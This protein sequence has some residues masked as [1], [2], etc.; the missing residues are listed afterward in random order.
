MKLV[1]NRYK[2][3]KVLE[4]N[5]YSSIYEVVD[6]WNDDKRLFMKLY[7]IDKQKKVIDYFINNFV[8]L[9]RIKHKYLLSSEQFSIIKTIDR[10]RVNIKQYYCTTE[11]ID[12][13]CLGK[14]HKD[15]SLHEKLM[16]I[17]QAC[18]VLDFLHYR[19]IVYKH[20]SP[21]NIFLSEDDNIKIMDLANVY[22]ASINTSYTDLTRYFIAPEVLLDQKDMINKNAD[23]YSLGML[24]LYL[25]T[26]DF[27]SS[28]ISYEYRDAPQ[29]NSRQIDFLNDLITRLTRKNPITREVSLRNLVDNLKEI[30]NIDYDYNIVKERGIL[31]FKTQIVGRE[32]EI[33]KVLM[34]DKK[35][36]KGKEY[37]K[38]ILINGDSGVGK[39]RL[40]KE[41][42]HLLRMRGRDVYYLEI[43]ENI[44]QGLKPATNILRQTIKDVPMNVLNKYAKELIKVLPE[45]KFVVNAETLDE[46]GGDRERLRLYDRITNYLEEFTKDKPVYL[47]IDNLGDCSLEFLHLLDY[48]IDNISEGSLIVIGSYNEK[49]LGDTSIKANIFYKLTGEETVEHIKISNLNLTEIGEFI[50][51]VLGIS[52][53]PL[54]FSAVMLRESAGNPRYIEYMMKDLYATGELFLSTEGF[55]EIK[56]QRYSD[57]YFPS[58]ID[59]AMKNQISLIE[60]G[61]LEIMKIVSVYNDSIS[62]IILFQMID[63]DN[64][65]LNTK[66]SELVGMGLLEEKV[67]DWGYSYSISNIHLKRLIYHR[68]PSYERIEL[69][70]KLA[71]LLEKNYGTNYKVI[72]EELIYHLRASH[73]T[74]KALDYTI[75]E[76]R[77]KSNIL[78]TQ[79]ILLWEEAYDIAKGTE[80]DYKLEILNSL[81]S[82]YFL[83][84]EYDKAL[85]VYKE[86]FDISKSKEE[87]KYIV[88]ANIGIGEIYL[89]RSLTDKALKK[90]KEAI[91]ISKEIDYP[92]GIVKSRILY[93]KIL[94]NHGKFDESQ[95]NIIELLDFVM[96]YDLYQELGDIYNIM[97][98]L[99][100]FNGNVE[101][102]IGLYRNSIKSYHQVDEFINSTKPINNIANIYRQYGEYKKA[103]EYYEDGLKI[104]EKYG[105]LNI[106]LVFLN[107]VGE[108]YF[109]LCDYDK[110]KK[111]IEEARTIALEVKDPNLIFL[112]NINLGLIYLLIGDYEHS[113]N[114]YEIIKE[115]YSQNS[116]FSFEVISQYYN[117]LGEFYYTFGKWDEALKYSTNSMKLCKDYN[118]TEYLM[119]KTR[120]ILTNYFKNQN[121]DKK[122]ME[123]IRAEFRS[124]NLGFQRRANLLR[125]GIVA[126]LENDYKYVADII[127]E[128]NKLKKDYTSPTLEY[129]RKLLLYSITPDEDS[130]KN[131]MKLEENMKKYNLVHLD[132]YA[133]ILIGVNFT[134]DEKY[135]QAI[136]Y[137][138]QSL[139]LI[140]GTIKNIPERDLQV[141]FIKRHR[142]DNIK[143]KLLEVMYKIFN[144]RLDCICID[145]IGPNDNIEKY[146]DY[147]SLFSLIDDSQFTKIT[148]MN[149]LYEETKDIFTIEDL[150]KNLTNDYKYNLKLILKYISK[151]AFAQRGYILIYDE[152]NNRYTPI[153]S[154][155]GHM[156]WKP[157]ENLLALAGRYE[158]GILISSSLVS[159]VIGL[160]KEFLPKDTRAL[161]CVP[162]ITPPNEIYHSGEERRKN[163]LQYNRR[164][165]GYIYLETGRIFNRFDKERQR[166]ISILTRILYINIEN[167][168]F[169]ILSNIDR[170]TGTYTRKYLDN[171][172]NRI[173]IEAKRKDESFA[174]MMMDLD[175]FKNIND[176]YGHRKGDEVLSL[177]GSTLSNSIR[178]TDIVAR[179]GGEEFIILLKDVN[180]EQV[181]KIG[182]K[183]RLSVEKL[184]ISNI[185]NPITIS[186][187]ISMFPV[188]SQFKEEL[189][190]KADQA[191]YCAKEKGRNKVVIWNTNLANT[192]N[193]VDRLAGILSGNTN[194]DQRNIL[195]ILDIIDIIK[196][197]IS[198][199]EKI[200]A[201]LGRTIETL[202][203]ENG[204]FIEVDFN[205]N[206]TNIYARSRLN[207]NWTE[208]SFINEAIVDRILSQRKG[209]FLID[210]E[211]VNE[212]N[213]V[214]NTPN[215]ESV[216]AI[217]LIFKDEIK[218][219]VYITVP[220]KEKEF[221]YNNY[222][223]TKVLCD[224]FSTLF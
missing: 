57:I 166:L 200:F 134:V 220:I 177:I 193:R 60:K 164:K 39:T 94:L 99:E 129:I 222:N 169:K 198:K 33:K 20:L 221:D 146:F 48:I 83:K 61:Y 215:W 29:M 150:I 98:L 102:A 205:N 6:F 207:Q 50:Q 65:Y 155:N 32:K 153:I 24:M 72:F 2:V 132:I 160:H 15:L 63:D 175:R 202:E 19:G 183:I 128:D 110:A 133:N 106:K 12:S 121:Y 158:N 40:L 138:L 73:Q 117:F 49:T 54:K 192:L 196:R 7:N 157:N 71:R 174:V 224:I 191:L 10:K 135:Y 219:L 44:Q 206:P 194:M 170:L 75:K 179:Y 125:L 211:S 87:G 90:A 81:G 199:K 141:G 45:L 69:H 25:L 41:T 17:I 4:D 147:N 66:I 162:I 115:S 185:E 213:L 5:I 167:Y 28:N 112:T 116:N 140:Y 59:E 88:I 42:S 113:Y 100:Y 209:E 86:L 204:A 91:K 188:H 22:E 165:E 151:E 77:E 186:I 37:K 168:K 26:N 105:I 9:T 58:S 123:D 38:A 85:N 96:E 154:L 68:I 173:L 152:E 51:Y 176:I 70:K 210:W 111:Y 187:G 3:N 97:G 184:K 43:T 93:N 67:A 74:E 82:I 144:K 145:D 223:L 23:K 64:D 163:Q 18:T 124:I 214:L 118:N 126:L 127:E 195:A 159:N 30:F 203:A 208:A 156:N 21:S 139:D 216:I 76:A 52:Y 53:K 171:E 11:Y 101:K 189:I 149:Y 143:I 79:S 119:S 190:E 84:G 47:I 1:D 131:L 104:V 80:S 122:S 161:I 142:T 55:W 89:K 180:E 78:S 62:K 201:F 14:I 27:Y 197:D 136:N 16:I 172:F 34:I 95:K 148:E 92:V 8:N 178:D 137:L 103:M 36:T 56:T 46:I 109:D 108:V 13:P 35:F 217:P 114:C 182:E 130:N 107:N 212:M 218:G 181:K 31:N 120:I